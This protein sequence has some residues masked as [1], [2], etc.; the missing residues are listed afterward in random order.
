MMLKRLD[1]F[2]FTHVIVDKKNIP[3]CPKCFSDLLLQR[4]TGSSGSPSRKRT[5]P[6]TPITP[7]RS[8][9]ET[10]NVEEVVG[11][12][13]QL[14]YDSAEVAAKI[15]EGAVDGRLLLALTEEDLVQE[16]GLSRLQAKKA[17][18]RLK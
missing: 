1:V 4:S 10:W 11:F 5:T 17:I 9:A 16:V 8:S 13:A 2:R 12:F 6:A 7:V 18:Q 14:G 15:R 3:P